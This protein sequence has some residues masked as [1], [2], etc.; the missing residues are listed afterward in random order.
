MINTNCPLCNH[1]ARAESIDGLSLFFSYDCPVCGKFNATTV[2]ASFSSS[3]LSHANRAVLSGYVR[4]MNT[5][6]R[7]DIKITLEN[8]QDILNS[9]IVA[10]SIGEKL[11][12]L[13][14]YLNRKADGLGYR[15]FTNPDTDYSVCYTNSPD[16]YIELAKEA[17]KRGYIIYRAYELQITYE[18]ILFAEKLEAEAHLSDSAFVAMWFSP[19]MFP[20]YDNA[21]KPAVESEECGKFKAFRVD[22]HEHNNDI[23]D[24]I[25]AGIKACRFMV[26]DLTGYRGGVYYEAGFAKGLGKPVIFTCRKDWFEGEI[27]PTGE[28]I[29]ERVHFDINHQNIIV[30]ENNDDLKKRII[31]R[32]RATII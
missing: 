29:K 17:H 23:T 22:N 2:F 8:Y 12:K 25:I 9:P 3:S 13:I 21:I 10:R 30:W 27:S 28:K 14:L 1:I 5:L 32:I 4:E 7:Q 24:E 31:N 15:V 18:G 6:E 11:K 20:I 19:E 26:A 16:E